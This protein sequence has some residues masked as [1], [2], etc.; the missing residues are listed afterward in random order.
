MSTAIVAATTELINKAVD[1]ATEL[2][3]TKFGFDA[4]QAKAFLKEGEVEVTIQTLE[5]SNMPWCGAVD[6]TCCDALMYAGGLYTQCTKKKVDGST[7]CKK[8]AKQVEKDGTPAQGDVH[9]RLAT[10]IME[11]KIGK[12]QVVP[13]SVYMA[14][15]GI[16]KEDAEKAAG[17]LGL[18]IDPRNFVEKKRGR[19]SK[20]PHAMTVTTPADEASVEAALT[21]ES[22]N[23]SDEE[24]EVS[25]VPAPSPVAPVTTAPVATVPAPSP[26]ET[27]APVAPAPVAQ[28]TTASVASVPAPAPV[29]ATASVATQD[30]ELVEETPKVSPPA[31]EEGEVSEEEEEEEEDDEEVEDDEVITYDKL[32]DMSKVEIF[33]IAAKQ[34]IS[35]EGLTPAKVRKAIMKKLGISTPPN[36]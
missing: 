25:V 36:A 14:K 5:K 26:V 23:G 4:E 18:T 34:S 10:D 32:I 30:V 6:A 29:V 24:E 13:F 33:A 11:Y 31:A 35:T 28:V 1:E 2:L 15:H 7:W 12:R 17:E 3:A 19:P 27:T 20:K 22:E 21:D 8:C 9:A 16:S